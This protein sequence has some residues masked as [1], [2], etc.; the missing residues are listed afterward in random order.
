MSSDQ[1]P[2]TILLNKENKVSGQWY[3]AEAQDYKLDLSKRDEILNHI[4]LLKSEIEELEGRISY[5][6]ELSEK[7]TQKIK[8][9]A[10]D[11]KS[12]KLT[13]F[14]SSELERQLQMTVNNLN[15]FKGLIEP[16]KEELRRD[17]IRLEEVA[18]QARQKAEMLWAMRLR[19]T[20]Q[21]A[22]EDAEEAVKS[23]ADI[24]PIQ[25]TL[26]RIMH[27][28]GKSSRFENS[29]LN[30]IDICDVFLDSVKTYINDMLK[31]CDEILPPE[32]KEVP[33]EIDEDDEN[34]D[35]DIFDFDD[36]IEEE[37]EEDEEE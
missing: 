27:E 28:G 12:S 19:P 21:A 9:A 22:L 31:Y 16:K 25:K 8:D 18:V 35:D 13:D 24:F 3:L 5:E 1:K 20:A 10:T 26:V 2:K 11:A 17:E 6:I 34:E 14:Q 23:I 29:L 37:E 32:K 36:E 7:I 30:P 15:T 4:S 33:K